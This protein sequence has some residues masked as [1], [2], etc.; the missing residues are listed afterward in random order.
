MVERVSG[1]L[2]SIETRLG[3]LEGE[4]AH[5]VFGSTNTRCNMDEPPFMELESR[6]AQKKSIVIAIDSVLKIIKS[7]SDTKYKKKRKVEKRVG[8]VTIV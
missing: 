5:G 2:G 3:Q 1:K 4:A 8:H 7:D 6:G